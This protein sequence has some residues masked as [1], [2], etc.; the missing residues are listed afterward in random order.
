MSKRRGNS[1]GR[2]GGDDARDEPLKA[3]D[4]VDGIPDRAAQRPM[5]KYVLIAAIFLGWLAFLVYCAAAGR[6]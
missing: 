1:S 4:S 2:P 6:L 3:I 5:W